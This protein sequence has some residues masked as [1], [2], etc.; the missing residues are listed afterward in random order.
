[1]RIII[2]GLLCLLCLG[3]AQSQPPDILERARR[4]AAAVFPQLSAA[5][6][7]I[8]PLANVDTTALGCRLIAGLPLATPI[9]A[10]RVDFT[11]DEE[12]FTVHVSADGGMI[13]PCDERFPNLGAGVI[14]VFRTR[15]DSDGDGL[16]DSAEAC[17]QI[18][19]LPALERAGCPLVSEADSDGDGSPDARDR[20]PLQAG[21]AATHGC[22]LMRDGDGDGV[23][24]QADICPA[25]S[26]VIRPDF[27]LGCPGDGGGSSPRRRGAN[28][29]CRAAGDAPIY[30]ERARDAEPQ[31]TLNDEPDAGVI[32]RT[33][34]SDW[35][36]LAG[37]WL[38]A[39]DAQLTGACYNIPLVNPTPGG[40]IG[41]FMRPL[42]EF[43]IAR[44][45][46]GGKQAARIRGD[47]SL[48]ALG[49]N[50]TGDWLFYHG[51]WVKRTVL[52]LSGA[53]D[54]LPIL[55]PAI[56]A[57][58]TV[59]FCPPEYHGM[60]PPRIDIGKRMARIASQSIA[61]R[62][63]AAPDITAEQIGE[64]PPR[65]VLDAVLDGPACKP[66]HIWWQVQAG[67]LI[68]WTAESD[69]DI[70]FYYLE[71]LANRGA[72]GQSGP[73]NREPSAS[74]KPASNRIIHSANAHAL[75]TVKLL[76]I[77]APQSLA[78]S[79][80]GSSLAVVTLGGSVELRRFPG[81]EAVPMQTWLDGEGRA[82]AAVFSP[83]AEVLAIGRADGSVVGVAL[84][85]EQSTGGYTLGALDGSIRALAWTR[86][87]DKLAAVSGDERLKIARRAGS[88][89]LWEVSNAAAG[90]QQ[91]LL[92]YTFP[93]PLTAVAFSA[94]D[95][96][97]AATGESLPDKRAGLWI[98]RVA[99]GAL[100]FSKALVPASG[101]ALALASPDPALGDFVY[102]S[103][104]SLYQIGIDSGDDQRLYHQAGMAL[105]SFA[106]RRQVIP[107]AEALL[108]VT[109]IERN[110]KKRLRIANALNHHSPAI[111]LDA[112][113]S[114]FAF[115]PDG[116]TL[117]IAEPEADRALIL[118]IPEP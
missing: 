93:Y 104:D 103:G 70:N 65:A 61:N 26:G 14:P 78:W 108:A 83:D 30:A 55:D 116:R 18:A 69:V 7:S 82:T 67:A 114:D 68:G 22:A 60:L 101:G 73:A 115:S 5:D 16:A 39:A 37:G 97:L 20:C 89:K 96:L 12:N 4:S 91:L 85:S 51:G 41:C 47:Q 52:E 49:R 80:I 1:M 74:E 33:A 90:E 54:Q 75:D 57:S 9:A 2:I 64:I 36:L 92:H 15:R 50:F 102:S 112:A 28:D 46:P 27:A 48:A 100:L 29:I 66:P 32:G 106:F 13:Q 44:T 35:Y 86:A 118:G 56:V 3:G 117:A 34:A 31:A 79:P 95:R 113:P 17:P 110:G 88:L 94:D 38:R 21:A 11:L 43:A 62:L 111:T 58:G 6:A 109:T 40:A 99:D 24:D 10:Y 42:A 98:Y 19:G 45:A 84:E 59:H 63:R 87:G 25:D 8:M 72:A 71:P 81:G 105:P 76:D 77:E 107:D 23:P 53:C